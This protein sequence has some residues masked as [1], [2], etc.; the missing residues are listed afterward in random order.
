MS[1]PSVH[2]FGTTPVGPIVFVGA[3]TII[4]FQS[5]G[6]TKWQ[7]PESIDLDATRGIIVGG[8]PL[9]WSLSASPFTGVIEVHEETSPGVWVRRADIESPRLGS[10]GTLESQEFGADVELDDAGCLLVGAKATNPDISYAIDYG[11]GVAVTGPNRNGL[12]TVQRV[13]AVAGTNFNTGCKAALAPAGNPSPY[14]CINRNGWSGML[15]SGGSTSVAA[16]S[17]ER[18]RGLRLYFTGRTTLPNAGS[19]VVLF[20]SS[21]P[22]ISGVGPVVSRGVNGLVGAFRSPSPQ[23]GAGALISGAYTYGWEIMPYSSANFG[24]LAGTSWTFQASY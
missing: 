8:C 4:P 20:G 22:A 1:A 16:F 21:S 6:I 9:A 5:G 10:A 17:A 2:V 7:V 24:A 12:V 23:A 18:A 19:F 3:P 15:R 14:G 11:N 13:A